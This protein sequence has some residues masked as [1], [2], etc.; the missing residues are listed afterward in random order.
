[1][2]QWLMWHDVTWCDCNCVCPFCHPNGQSTQTTSECKFCQV[3]WWSA[4]AGCVAWMSGYVRVHGTEGDWRRI[5]NNDIMIMMCWAHLDVPRLPRANP[6]THPAMVQ[7]L[8]IWHIQHHT[9]WHIA[10]HMI[11]QI[12]DSPTFSNS[13]RSDRMARP[14]VIHHQLFYSLGAL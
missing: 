7:Y 4:I 3:L 2:L 14:P 6:S 8:H 5:E 11:F 9:T 10:W 12:S 1:M 13:Q